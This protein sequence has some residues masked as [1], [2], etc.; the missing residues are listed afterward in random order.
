VVPCLND[1]K[2]TYIKGVDTIVNYTWTCTPGGSANVNV[3]LQKSFGQESRMT[4]TGS[5]ITSSIDISGTD[6]PVGAYQLQACFNTCG[7]IVVTSVFTITAPTSS[8]AN[9]LRNLAL[10][11]TGNDVKRLQAF[12]VNEVTYSTDLITGYFGR[13]TRDAVKKLQEKYDIQPVSGYFGEITRKA[14]NALISHQ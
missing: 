12:L 9:F 4:L 13:I 8:K 14:L 2:T 1:G 11:S 10:G 3:I 7:S 5:S 6:Y